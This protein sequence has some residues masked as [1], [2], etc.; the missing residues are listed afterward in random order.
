MLRRALDA[1][2]EASWVTADEVYGGDSKFRQFLEKQG[3]GY[4]VAVSCQQRLFLH[5]S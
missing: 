3:M 4:V 1:G 5:G 2:V